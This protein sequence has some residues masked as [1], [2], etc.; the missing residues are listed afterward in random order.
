[1]SNDYE[2]RDFEASKEYNENAEDFDDNKS[3][4]NKKSDG[5][6]SQGRVSY[7]DSRNSR[8]SPEGNF[9]KED[10]IHRVG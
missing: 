8:T 10:E 6:H 2:D 5:N 9:S 4:Q 3:K 1:M 7:Q